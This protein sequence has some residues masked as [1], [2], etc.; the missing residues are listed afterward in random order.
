MRYSTRRYPGYSELHGGIVNRGHDV[1]ILGK[2]K[3]SGP[4]QL[5]EHNMWSYW[6]GI[7][8]RRTGA[9]RRR[10]STRSRKPLCHAPAPAA[11]APA[12][13]P[14]PLSPAA[15]CSMPPGG[16]RRSYSPASAR[17]RALSCSWTLAQ[18][19]RRPPA[20]NP[21]SPNRQTPALARGHIGP[22][23]SA[24]PPGSLG[25]ALATCNR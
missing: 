5:E 10:S 4:S 3:T 11:P 14:A 18:S 12:P 2:N 25:G 24:P 22:P 21:R 23:T 20:A 6:Y 8:S 19:A 1:V 7:R 13:A 16:Q 15:C 17:H 9:T